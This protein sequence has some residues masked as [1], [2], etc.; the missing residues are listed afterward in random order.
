[1]LVNMKMLPQSSHRVFAL[2]LGLVI[3][4]LLSIYNASA[5]GV[6][7]ARKTLQFEPGLEQTVTFKILNNEHKDFTAYVYAEGD[8]KEYV[9]AEKNIIEFKESDDSKPFT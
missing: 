3:F 1:M 8:L 5:I 7:P 2:T 6:T 4:L 9:T